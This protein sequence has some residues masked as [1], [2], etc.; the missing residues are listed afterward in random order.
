MPACVSAPEPTPIADPRRTRGLTCCRSRPGW[1]P[2]G[3]RRP[4]WTS[5]SP[6]SRAGGT[7]PWSPRRGGRMEGR[8]ARGRRA[9][10]PP[11]GR[12]RATP[13][14]ILA[15]GVRLARLARARAGQPAARPL[16]RAGVQRPHRRPPLRRRAAGHHLSRHLSGAGPR[17]SAGTMRVMTR[18]DLVIANSAFTRD[19]I[20]AEHPRRSGARSSLVP[21]GIDTARFDPAAVSR[22]AHRPRCAPT[23]ASTP[24]DTRLVLLLAA[25]PAAWKGHAL[26]IEALAGAA[27]RRQGRSLMLAGA[28]PGRAPTPP[29]SRGGRRA[30]ASPRR[31]GCVPRARRHAAGPRRR[32]TSS[33]PPRSRRSPSAASVVEAAAMGRPVLASA[34]GAQ[35]ETIVATATG[36]LAPPPTAAAWS[37]A[38]DRG[39]G[40]AARRRRVAMG[41]AAR[42]RALRAL[43]PGRHGARRPSPPT[44]A[45]R[46]QRQRA[47]SRI[48]RPTRPGD[49]ARR[50]LG[51][52]VLAFPAFERIRAAHPEARDHPADHRRRSP[53]WPRAGPCFDAVE[54]GRPAG[55]ARA[56]GS[57]S[58]AGCAGARLRPGLRPADQRPHQPALPGA[59][60]RSAARGRGPPSAAPCPTATRDRMRMHALERQA[61][62]LRDAGIWP[63]APTAPGS[64]AR[65]R[66]WAGCSRAPAAVRARSLAPNAAPAGRC[67]FPAASPQSAGEALAGRALRA[68]LARRLARPGLARRGG[69]RRGRGEPLAATPSGAR[70]PGASDLTG[71]HRPRPAR[72]PRRARAALAVGNDTG[73]AHLIAAA[74]APTLVLF[75]GDSDP[76]LCAPRGRVSRLRGAGPRRP[77]SSVRRRL[78]RRASSVPP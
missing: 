51:D 2:A 16:P 74:G 48:A 44:G 12:T 41:E 76:A 9:P 14:R 18:G 25:R 28:R 24:G 42:R 47:M 23:G 13:L 27:C 31:C 71:A 56:T 52:F 62:Q 78:W 20:L 7:G 26:L 54:D 32:P 6:W 39:P 46:R 67:S 29:T 55:A 63:D 70:A 35:A 21:E 50:P 40:D 75:S 49:Q 38:I 73:P 34:L 66:T 53:S 65:R 59:A 11:A 69:R 33:S 45:H 60:A 77:R 64:R 43:Q 15:N 17:P 61:E 3:S 4:P 57:A 30:P 10:R 72:R 8:L 68:R 22:R 58:S 36:W 1:T 37:A 5:P 19:H